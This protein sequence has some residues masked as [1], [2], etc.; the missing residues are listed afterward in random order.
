[1]QMLD[2]AVTHIWSAEAPL[3]SGAEA[4]VIAGIWMGHSAVLKFRHPR[5]YRHPE[6]ERRVV[7]SRMAA[8]ASILRILHEKGLPVPEVLG[9]L[10][11]GRILILARIQG[12]PL[13]EALDHAGPVDAADLLEK[14]GSLLRLLH[15]HEIVHGDPTTH[16]VIVGSNGLSLVDFG[17]ARRA[18]ELEHLGLDLHVLKESL[19]ARHSGLEAAM[20][21]VLSGYISTCSG[22]DPLGV[23]V[24]RR[25]ESILGRVRYHG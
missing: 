9:T 14:L 1:M 20:N 25:F 24:V 23:S 7:R 18:P 11:E 3:H 8:E 10:R 4:Q 12:N 16:N 19:D 2:C 22:H 6:L 21:K 5:T 17:L 13:C 15:E